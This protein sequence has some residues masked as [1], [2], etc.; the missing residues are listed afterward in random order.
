MT[1]SEIELREDLEDRLRFETMLADL[2][3]R[4]VAL[5]AEQVDGAIEDAQRHIVEALG[6]DRSSLFQ[7]GE[8]DTKMTHFWVRPGLPT[9]PP[10]LSATEHYPWGFK[11]VIVNGDIVRFSSVDE[12]PPEAARDV[13]SIQK[14]GLKSNVTL[15]LVGG[16]RVIGALGFATLREERQWPDALVARLRLVADLFANALARKRA[17][18]ELTRSYR[19][20]RQLKDRLQAESEYLKGEIAVRNCH[21]EILGQSEAIQRVLQQVE[22]VAPTEST[23]L[24]QGETG[25]GKELVARAIHRLSQRKD[26]VMVTVN[27]ASLPSSLIESELFGRERGAYTGALTRQVG[28]FELANGSTIFLDEVGELAAELQAKLLRVLQE[29]EIER[30]GSPKTIRVDV[31]VIAASNRDLADAVHQGTFREDLYY[32]LNVFPI[33]IPPLRERPEDIPQLVWAVA[34]EFAV[35]VGKTID[36]IPR[37]AIEALQRYPWPGNVRELRNVIERAVITSRGPR[38]DVVVPRVPAA[39]GGDGMSMTLETVER[40]HILAVLDQTGWRIR[41][42]YGAARYLGLKPTTLE[43]RMQKLGIRRRSAEPENR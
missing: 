1:E 23:V 8:Q 27:C 28:R 3:A 12:L 25:S 36:T 20:I 6:I 13:D 35:S 39:L 26:R 34:Q 41:G 14:F 11:K 4:F 10:E 29:R 17:H 21:D 38:L 24:I 16:G 31:R 42:E 2:S 9:F 18:E 40:R 43:A 22:Q 19:E 37:S 5:S 15:P 33:S 7:V 30:L 32:R